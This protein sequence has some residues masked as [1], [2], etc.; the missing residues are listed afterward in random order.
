MLDEVALA[1]QQRDRDEWHAKI[2]GGTQRIAGEY[3]KS[4]AVGGY[5]LLQADFHGEVGH[6]R[7]CGA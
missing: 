4:T 1:M 2:G 5:G 7:S 6:C 3:S